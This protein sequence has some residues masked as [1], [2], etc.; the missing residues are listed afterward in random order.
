MKKTLMLSALAVVSFTNCFAQQEDADKYYLRNSLYMIKLD[1]VAT[2]E[3][4]ANAY[5]IMND[6]YDKIDFDKNYE[7]YN[8]FALSLRHIN[9]K[10]LP[11]VSQDEIDAIGKPSAVE[12]AVDEYMKQN[13]FKKEG[14]L[15]E[16]EYA[17][18]L[19]KYLA[20]K[21]IAQKLVAKWYNVPGTPEG[22]V[23]LDIHLT[24]IRD[25]GLKGLS[26]EAK[27]AAGKDNIEEMA[28]GSTNKLLSNCYVCVNRYNY[29]SADEYKGVT[30]AAAKVAASF[31]PG[32]AQTLF[33]KGTEVAVAKIQGYFV[34]VNSYLFK[35]EWNDEL[36]QKVETEYWKDDPAVQQKLLQDDAFKLVYVGKSSKNAPAALTF[37][38]SALDKLIERGTI[39]ATDRA[40]AA[41]QRDYEEFR[42]MASLQEMNGKLIAYIGMK[43]DVKSGDKFEVFKPEI[44]PDGTLKEW[45]EVGTIKVNK[46][47]VWDNRAG[48][49]EAIEGEA[50]DKKE[51][52]DEEGGKMEWTEFKDKPSKNVY[53]GLMIRMAK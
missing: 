34:K 16:F 19:S 15:S 4:Y 36:R 51:K 49:G 14:S 28:K 1:E 5:Q 32:L 20:D 29:I 12:K 37:K 33:L 38:A 40:F 13:G 31:M 53:G 35:L 39:R 25:L 24:T 18:R 10:D 9:F 45:K 3:E 17:A 26:E 21:R 43:E 11:E 42:P 27:N 48:A 8:D 7:R 22:K 6:T 41:L 52:D 47:C 44:N 30:L 50:V 46:G 23:N 2:D